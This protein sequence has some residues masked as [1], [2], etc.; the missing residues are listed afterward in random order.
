M[1]IVIDSNILFSA[2]IKDSYTRRTILEY[3]DKF[4][5]PS[6]IFDE[7]DKHRH[8]LLRKSGMDAADFGLLLSILLLKVEIVPKSQLDAHYANAI[9]I[10]KDIDPDDVPFIAC[11]LAHPGSIIWSDDKK[12]SKQAAVKVIGTDKISTYL[13]ANYNNF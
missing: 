11:A 4:L 9:F 6:Y 10:V 8:E 13:S 2:L 12:L 5:F 3:K 7:F 1:R